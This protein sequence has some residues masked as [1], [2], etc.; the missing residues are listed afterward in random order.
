MGQRQF[1]PIKST[2]LKTKN[3]LLETQ[4]IPDVTPIQQNGRRVPIHLQEKVENDVKN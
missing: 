3:H 1:R 2:L 4:L